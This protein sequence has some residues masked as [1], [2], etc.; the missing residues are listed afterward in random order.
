MSLNLMIF[1]IKQQMF[2]NK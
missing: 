2:Q 1:L